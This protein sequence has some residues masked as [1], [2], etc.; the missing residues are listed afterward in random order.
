MLVSCVG[1]KTSIT[2]LGCNGWVAC[3]STHKRQINRRKDGSYSYARRS[4]WKRWLAPSR[5]KDRGLY[6]S[7]ARKGKGR[8]GDG[9]KEVCVQKTDFL[10]CF[11]H[12]GVDLQ[13]SSLDRSQPICLLVFACF[14]YFVPSKVHCCHCG[15]NRHLHEKVL[16]C[17]IWLLRLILS[18][19]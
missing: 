3:D 8:L 4:A 9:R 14:S 6:T 7:L 2:I 13:P 16:R 18:L 10:H 19:F 15:S 17:S 1:R 5:A 12:S 11:L